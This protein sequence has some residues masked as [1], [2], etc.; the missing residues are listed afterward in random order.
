MIEAI[1]VMQRLSLPQRVVL[2]DLIASKRFRFLYGDRKFSLVAT[3]ATDNGI[4]VAEALAYTERLEKLWSSTGRIYLFAYHEAVKDNKPYADFRTG[5]EYL[6]RA[7]FPIGLI[8]SGRALLA[9]PPNYNTAQVD[10]L[11][12]KVVEALLL[13]GNANAERDSINLIYGGFVNFK[14]YGGVPKLHRS[15]A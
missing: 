1:T 13:G 7:T 9:H 4:E 2:E 15:K 11:R 12:E 8:S 10:Q 14:R 6:P 5:T 3:V